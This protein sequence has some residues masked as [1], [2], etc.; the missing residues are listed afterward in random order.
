M[1]GSDQMSIFG[2]WNDRLDWQF[3]AV[4][5]GPCHVRIMTTAYHALN[6]LK[7]FAV[8]SLNVLIRLS[9]FARSHIIYIDCNPVKD[10]EAWSCSR[11][12]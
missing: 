9:E 10:G 5:D 12:E 3:I 4:P 8:W 1:K 2:S 11:I 6:S 7:H